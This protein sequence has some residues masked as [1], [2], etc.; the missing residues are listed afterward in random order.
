MLHA[1]ET[2]FTVTM[3]TE[4]YKEIEKDLLDLAGNFQSLYRFFNNYIR[5]I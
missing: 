5:F 4:Y 1:S 2:K 3:A